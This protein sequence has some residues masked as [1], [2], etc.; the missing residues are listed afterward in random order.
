[1]SQKFITVED[2]L[3]A[4]NLLGLKIDNVEKRLDSQSAGEVDN[5]ELLTVDQAAMILKVAKQTIYG[6]ICR[7]ELKTVK[8]KG[9]KR[10][11]IR[12]SYL[13]EYIESGSTRAKC[14]SEAIPGNCLIRKNK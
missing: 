6:R 5:S 7:K 11:Y 14:E 10:V 4:I 13:L 3:I 8:P 12:K 1:M 2:L 9:S